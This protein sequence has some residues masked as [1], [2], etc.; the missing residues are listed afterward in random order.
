MCVSVNCAVK[1]G[2]THSDSKE[3]AERKTAPL[4]HTY[5]AW[6]KQHTQRLLKMQEQFIYF[7]IIRNDGSFRENGERRRWN[8]KGFVA[9]QNGDESSLM[10]PLITKCLC[11]LSLH[12]EQQ[13]IIKVKCESSVLTSYHSQWLMGAASP[14]T[15]HPHTPAS[16]RPHTDLHL[17]TILK[18][19]FRSAVSL[20]VCEK[21]VS[22]HPFCAPPPWM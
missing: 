4:Y 11:P 15:Q 16:L 2:E 7:R 3:T 17:F 19:C 10:L 22:V 5:A 9:S 8:K 12:R 14:T 18:Q 21:F 13:K 1:R 6:I 20:P